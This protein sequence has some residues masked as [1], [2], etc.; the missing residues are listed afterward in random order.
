MVDLHERSGDRAIR[1]AARPQAISFQKQIPENPQLF[2]WMGPD[3][4]PE[5][6]R[7]VELII[8]SIARMAGK[9]C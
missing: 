6:H 7:G 1:R 3:P 4:V 9:T 2:P 5:A 8:H